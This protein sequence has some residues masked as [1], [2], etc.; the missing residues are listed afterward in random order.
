MA[1][2]RHVRPSRI[3]MHVLDGATPKGPWYH[4]LLALPEFEAVPFSA[5]DVPR[6]LNGRNVTHPAHLS[7]F[8]RLQVRCCCW[9]VRVV[10]WIPVGTR[11]STAKAMQSEGRKLCAVLAD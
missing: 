7:D 4:A 3:L 10:G 8:R 11:A 2:R 5:D 1:A 6:H 9:R